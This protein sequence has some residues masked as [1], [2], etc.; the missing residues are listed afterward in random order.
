MSCCSECIVEKLLLKLLVN[1][2]NK[3][4]NSNAP[5][6]AIPYGTVRSATPNNKLMAAEGNYA[7]FKHFFTEKLR[8]PAIRSMGQVRFFCYLDKNKND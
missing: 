5:H 3:Y 6:L 4:N 8:S 2:R 1:P 7:C